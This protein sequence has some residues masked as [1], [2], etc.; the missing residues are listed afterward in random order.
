MHEGVDLNRN[1]GYKWAYDNFGSSDDPCSEAYRGKEPF[2]EP[3]TQ[4]LKSFIDQKADILDLALNFHA[5]GNLLV[6]PYNFDWTDENEQ[7]KGEQR[8][9]YE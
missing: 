2:S 4:A 5:Y 8:Q 6:T 9:I 7:L 3:E 1:F